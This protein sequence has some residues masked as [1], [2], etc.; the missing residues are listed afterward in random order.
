MQTI[1]RIIHQIWFGDQP[2]P[3]Q[4]QAWS[5]SLRSHH[6]DW[7]Y[8][9]W[10]DE[11]C[12]HLQPLMKKCKTLAGA[13]NVARIYALHA[14]GGVYLDFDIECFKPLDPLL[15]V[16]A[17]GAYDGGLYNQGIYASGEPII[18]NAIMACIPHHRWMENQ[19]LVLPEWVEKEPPWGP[20]LA[21]THFKDDVHLYP[22]EYFYPFTWYDSVRKPHENS[23]LIHHWSGL[24]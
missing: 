22:T 9:L 14:F 2:I 15:N 13:S 10:R 12:A 24:W 16:S 23:F 6:L 20:K 19:M 3:R 11:D 17:F 21:T 7:E 8:R 1:P 4:L 18:C 5:E